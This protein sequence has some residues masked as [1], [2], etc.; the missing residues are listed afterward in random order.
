MFI[1]KTYN[2]HANSYMAKP[3]DFAQFINIIRATEDFWLTVAKLSS[4]R[5]K[6]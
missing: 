5:S 1:L 6:I 3:F 4:G 2:L